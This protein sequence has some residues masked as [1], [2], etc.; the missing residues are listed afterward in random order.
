MAW[1]KPNRPTVPRWMAIILGLLTFLIAIP[2]AHGVLPWAIS[3]R[4]PRY[5]WAEGTPGMWNRLGLILVASSAKGLVSILLGEDENPLI[6]DLQCRFPDAR[7]VR[8]ARIDDE[9]RLKRV[10]DFA[11]TPSLGLDLDRKST[12]LNSSHE[13]RSRMPSSA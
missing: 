3:T 1:P 5:G 7:L 4:M 11:E 6:E 12:R 13:R 9:Q 8:G 10:L 2:L